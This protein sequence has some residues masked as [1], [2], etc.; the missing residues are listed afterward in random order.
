MASYLY[1][2]DNRWPLRSGHPEEVYTRGENGSMIQAVSV[3]G[4]V[5]LAQHQ[6]AKFWKNKEK[7]TLPQQ[8]AFGCGDLK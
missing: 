3:C 8:V 5:H 7:I 1:N 4:R 2:W 6:F